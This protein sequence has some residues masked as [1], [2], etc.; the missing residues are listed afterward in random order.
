ML[1]H[2]IDVGVILCCF[3]FAAVWAVK[4]CFSHVYHNTNAVLYGLT[5]VDF[6]QRA[7]F[8]KLFF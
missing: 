2:Q 6:L 3:N 5:D 7:V 4:A 8:F 1:R